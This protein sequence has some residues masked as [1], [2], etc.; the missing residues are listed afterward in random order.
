MKYK[1]KTEAFEWLVH[2][3]K[4]TCPLCSANI[5]SNDFSALNYIE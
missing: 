2:S 1:N 4:C 3:W 5:R